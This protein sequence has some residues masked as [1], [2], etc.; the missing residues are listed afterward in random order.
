MNKILIAATLAIGVGSALWAQDDVPVF[1]V[2]QE[3]PTQIFEATD[4]MPD[5][6]LWQLRP[7]IIFADNPLDPRFQRQMDLVSAEIDELAERDVIVIVDTDP[8]ARSTWRTMLRPRG[9]MLALLAKDGTM[10]LRKPLP[11]NVRE[12]SASIDKI[13]LRQQ[14]I[15]DRRAPPIR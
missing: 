15:E 6:I 8:T 4:M 2:W 1:E 10:Q 13:P 9:F 12:L 3:T 14:E 7:L 5:D 11:S